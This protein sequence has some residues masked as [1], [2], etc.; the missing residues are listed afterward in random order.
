M[1]ETKNL[2]EQLNEYSNSKMYP[3]HIPGHKRR[4]KNEL[5][6]YFHD[7]TE[8]DGLDNLYEAEGILKQAMERARKC[9]D[10]DATFYLVNGSTCGIITSIFATTGEND[11]VLMARNCHGSVYKAIYL[12]GL[13]PEYIIP[14]SI[15]NTDIFG[16]VSVADIEEKLKQQEDIKAVIITSPTYEGVVSDV[17]SI[18]EVVH[19][20]GKI[21]IV[22]EAHGSHL[23]F[24][25]Y[26]PESAIKCGADIVIH[27]L[28]KTMGGL[29]Q[30]GLLHVKGNRV[31][32]R[33]IKKYL[34]MF[35]T[36]S[37]SYVLMGSIDKAVCQVLE[38][39]TELFDNYVENLK[40]FTK[41]VENLT[42]ISLLNVENSK[43]SNIFRVDEGKLVIFIR[44]KYKDAK[45]LYDI[46]RDK[47][48]LQM[49]MLGSRY[50]LAITSIYDSKEGFERL[51]KALEDVDR[52]IRIDEVYFSRDKEKGA[53]LIE[54]SEPL[55]E[56]SIIV[57]MTPT[58]TDK[59]E[60]ELLNISDAVGKISC[61]YIY[62][63]PPGI[64][65]LAPGEIITNSIARKYVQY[66]QKG[67]NIYGPEYN[68]ENKIIV[69]KE[70]FK[71]WAGF[72]T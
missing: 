21:L 33:E 70:E 1:L 56:K 40:M 50:V 61:E 6:P 17:K 22:D 71:A 66:K 16:S 36:S 35:Q 51:Y 18:A 4:E 26:F 42:N 54:K 24:H 2:I 64:P 41:N 23:G 62:M 14:E 39:G 19:K 20:Y 15:G 68:D 63:Y 46:L 12:R 47:Y 45:Y 28:H 48:K 8:V 53:G 57:Q 43:N 65:I 9:Y 58:E 10:A 34:G 5:N 37:P 69:V 32:I 52:E 55:F 29:T 25:S 11:K 3:F 60:K 27:S 31:N 59:K 13:R 72:F 67:Y 7:V 30:T 49:E 44:S 38:K